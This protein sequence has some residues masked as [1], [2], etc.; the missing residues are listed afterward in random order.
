MAF[1]PSLFSPARPSFDP[2]LAA[3]Q[4]QWL[5]ESAWIDIA[6]EWV[7]GAD[8]LFEELVRTRRWVQRKRVMYGKE[9]LEPRLTSYWL[10]ASEEPL[11]PPFIEELR[12]SLSRKYGVLFDSVGFNYYRDGDDSVALHRDHISAE[13]REP[14]VALVSLGER[15]RFHLRPLGGGATRTWQLGRG[16]LLVTGGLTQR[17]WE[18]GVPKAAHAG[19]RISLA[20]RHGMQLA[21]YLRS[22]PPTRT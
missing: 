15:R 13:I 18:H 21:A 10:K 2:T 3:V 8:G 4:R 14:V 6:P 12:D 17:T 7:S 16:D 22:D 11:L 19:P 5:D 9:L 1:Q 20:F